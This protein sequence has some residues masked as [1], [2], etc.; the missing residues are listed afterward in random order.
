[1]IDKQIQSIKIIFMCLFIIFSF[2]K[3]YCKPNPK[4]KK[5]LRY[6]LFFHYLNGL[7]NT[8]LP[9]NQGKVT[10]WDECVNDFN[11]EK[12]A[13]QAKDAKADYIIFTS[14]Q[15]DKFICFPNA[16]YENVTGY[17]RGEATSKRDLISDLYTALNKRGIKL[18]LYVTG[19]GPRAD[20]QASVALKNPSISA[21]NGKFLV[22]SVWV[23]SWSRFIRSISLQYK[24]K[25]TGY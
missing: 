5:Q 3:I 20:N 7:Q 23:K 19:D 11:V 15:I 22:D 4:L 6:G 8:K 12:L 9:W 25:L 21:V 24:K 1:M 13:E 18:F 14:Q 17:T 2:E 16:T 10:S